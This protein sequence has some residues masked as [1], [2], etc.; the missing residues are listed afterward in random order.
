M[1]GFKQDRGC[2]ILGRS[3]LGLIPRDRY[4][5]DTRELGNYEIGGEKMEW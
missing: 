2:D 5:F 1:L 3:P 4:D